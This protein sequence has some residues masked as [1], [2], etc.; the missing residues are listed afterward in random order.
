MSQEIKF[1]IKEYSDDYKKQV[2]ELI[3]QVYENSRGRPR[4]ERPDLNVI[5]ETYQDSGGNFW[6]AI[7]KNNIIG[8]IGLRDQG[9]KRASMH[10]FAVIENFRGKEKGVSTKLFFTLLEFAKM[11]GFKKIFLGTLPDAIPAM[12]FYE[13]N[14][15]NNI[16]SLPKDLAKHPSLMYDT[17]FYK[18]DLE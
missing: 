4:R 1:E 2:N 13:R 17:V 7:N 3:F 9:K 5:K 12:K 16:K 6:V 18:L 15:F 11:K 8:T 14:G 10:R